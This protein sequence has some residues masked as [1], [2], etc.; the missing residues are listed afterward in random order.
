MPT[1]TPPWT[2]GWE[3][4]GPPAKG[5]ARGWRR[6]WPCGHT[7]VQPSAVLARKTVPVVGVTLVQ[8]E[9]R[10]RCGVPSGRL[11]CPGGDVDAAAAAVPTHTVTHTH[12]SGG[13]GWG[14]GRTAVRPSTP[15]PVHV[16][17]SLG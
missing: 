12:R 17:R 1:P 14:G 3:D 6:S 2:D 7:P 10:A 8:D 5:Q 13:W 9:A 16:T 11:T 4:P 15:S